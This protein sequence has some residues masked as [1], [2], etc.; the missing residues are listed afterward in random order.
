MPGC[1]PSPENT[2]VD[3]CAFAVGRPREGERAGGAWHGHSRRTALP[4][5]QTCVSLKGQLLAGRWPLLSN[6]QC[7]QAKDQGEGL[8]GCHKTETNSWPQKA[9]GRKGSPPLRTRSA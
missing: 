7:A 4:A 2:C 9:G 3:G 6:L 8:W 5:A 1:V